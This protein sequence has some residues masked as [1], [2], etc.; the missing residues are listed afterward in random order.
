MPGLLSWPRLFSQF[1]SKRF[2]SCSQKE[3]KKRKKLRKATSAPL[4]NNCCYLPCLHMA[5][6]IHT[7]AHISIHVCTHR[8]HTMFGQMSMCS[9][10]TH[11]VSHQRYAYCQLRSPILMTGT[12]QTGSLFLP[13]FHL[14]NSRQRHLL[15]ILWPNHHDR[16]GLVRNVVIEIWLP[17]YFFVRR[18]GVNILTSNLDFQQKHIATVGKRPFLQSMR[19]RQ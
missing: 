15:V 9:V 6:L 1:Q 7:C 19:M 5:V 18:D 14:A 16:Q 2:V 10:L 12:K 8:T 13:I 4:Q 3:K 11:S 17:S